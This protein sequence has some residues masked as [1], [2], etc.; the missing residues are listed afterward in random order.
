M[1][2]QLTSSECCLCLRAGHYLFIEA[3]RPQ[4]PGD[5]AILQSQTFPATASRCLTFWYHMLGT[6][7]GTLSVSMVMLPSNK[8]V[9]LWSLSGNQQDQWRFARVPINSQ[10]QQ[11]LLQLQGTVGS[12]YL[13]DLA[14][15]DLVFT[16][17]TCSCESLLP[18]SSRRRCSRCDAVWPSVVLR[19]M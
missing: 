16:T 9:T 18:V 19:K 10:R 6:G 3:S 1:L 15:D 11:Y 14:V 17:S 5:R 7:I 4:M 13:G 2:S 12:S 8:S